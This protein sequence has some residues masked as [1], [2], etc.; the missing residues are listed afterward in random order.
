MHITN[1][2]FVILTIL[3]TMHVVI[4]A[5]LNLRDDVLSTGS[6]ENFSSTDDSGAIY[7]FGTPVGGTDS[8]RD[9]NGIYHDGRKRSDNA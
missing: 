3:S 6:I 7:E 2:A 5:P 9:E 1:A 8:W 4:T